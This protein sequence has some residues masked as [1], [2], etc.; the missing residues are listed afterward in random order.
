MY[1][2]TTLA[3]TLLA[4]GVINAAPLTTPPPNGDQCGPT[5]QIPGDPAD[6]CKGQPILASPGA[7]PG[8]YSITPV[9]AA[10]RSMQ[11]NP[12]TCDPVIDELCK[13]M[14]RADVTLGKW[15]FHTNEV[16]NT[17]CQ[18]GFYLPAQEGAAPKPATVGE[19]GNTGNQCENILGAIRWAARDRSGVFTDL[20]A[21]TVNLVK[22]PVGVE[23]M[24]GM[25]GDE[26]MERTDGQAVNAG[27]PSYMWQYHY[28]P[29]VP[30]D[31]IGR[32]CDSP[33]ADETCDDYRTGGGGG[34]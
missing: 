30:T 6:T 4:V 1:R 27:Y 23:G 7:S 19:D 12:S 8:A 26:V 28:T 29:Y 13:S 11:Y 31:A 15:Y 9:P 14:A 22:P 34:K 10:D 5:V 21:E 20:A 2:L 18:M 32:T 3:S 17:A 16:G 25:D 24:W 33:R